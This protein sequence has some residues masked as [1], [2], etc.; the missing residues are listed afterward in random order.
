MN[1][2][3]TWI[4]KVK[5]E[6][7]NSLA[8]G[9]RKMAGDLKIK[10]VP[11]HIYDWRRGDRAIPPFIFNYMMDDVIV[12]LVRK[13]KKMTIEDQARYILNNTTIP[14]RRKLRVETDGR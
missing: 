1:I 13:S 6:D 14:E 12:S 8:A 10:I 3:D 11:S 9:V 5:T 2:I 4:D 7:C